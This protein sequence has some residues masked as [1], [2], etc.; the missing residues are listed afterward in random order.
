[1]V[2]LVTCWAYTS[3]ISYRILCDTDFVGV[4]LQYG[5]LP[6]NCPDP[7]QLLTGSQLS[8]PQ[9]CVNMCSEVLVDSNIS[10][11]KQIKP[12]GFRTHYNGVKA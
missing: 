10:Q 6:T 9:N 3:S 8:L 4:M 1:M 5:A 2:L 11:M 7:A 12:A